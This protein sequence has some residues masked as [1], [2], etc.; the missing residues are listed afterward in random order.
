MRY[1]TALV[2]VAALVTVGTLIAGIAAMATNSEVGHHPSEEWMN[3]RVAAQGAA[4]LFF[5]LSQFP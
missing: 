4:L 1:M 3:W 5:V 2:I